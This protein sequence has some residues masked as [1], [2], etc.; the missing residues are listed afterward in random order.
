MNDCLVRLATL[1]RFG[2]TLGYANDDAH[3]TVAATEGLVAPPLVLTRRDA[4]RLP[5]QATIAHTLPVS[6]AVGT[7]AVV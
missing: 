2:S 7:R 5:S 4:K 3:W 6:A 1:N